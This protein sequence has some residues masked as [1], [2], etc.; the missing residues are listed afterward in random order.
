MLLSEL[1]TMR[2]GGPATRMVD[3]TTKPQLVDAARA[4][5]ADGDEWF[6][7][8]GGSNVV[9]S[10]D[11]FDGTVIRTLTRGIEVVAEGD[12]VRLTAQAG[13]PWDAVVEYAVSNGLAGIEALSGIPGSTGAAPIQ[14][15]GAYGQEVGDTLVAVEFLDY[16]SGDVTRLTLDELGFGYRTSVIKRG[17][18]G[19][20]LSVEFELRR[21]ERGPVAYAQ[22]AQALGVPLG[23]EVSIADVRASVLALRAAKGM[24]L[25]PADPDSTSCGSFFTNPIVDEN[26]AR[27][28]PVDAPRWPV[29]ADE[30]DVVVPLGEQPPPRDEPRPVPGEAQRGVAHRARRHREGFRVAGLEGGHLDEAHAGDHQSRRGHRRPGHPAR[31]VRADASARAVRRAT[32]RGARRGRLPAVAPRLRRR[33]GSGSPAAPRAAPPQRR[34]LHFCWVAGVGGSKSGDLDGGTG[35]AQRRRRPGCRG[36]SA[37]EPT[38]GSPTAVSPPANC[39]M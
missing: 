25:D 37:G 3:A 6:V 30:P 20:V 29:V 23:T 12:S 22:L 32:P 27:R 9:V 26:F 38:P 24:V 19:V 35:H 2:V 17:R 28:L 13:E 18:Q 4:A 36:Y 7:L 31:A 10:D 1:T 21:S 16:D 34:D 33:A 15:I 39:D 14:N 5:W 8:G 11:G